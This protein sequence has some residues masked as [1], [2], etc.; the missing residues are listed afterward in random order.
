M[1][2]G[3][4]I[5][6]DSV[7]EFFYGDLFIILFADQF[8][9]GAFNAFDRFDDAQIFISFQNQ[10]KTFLSTF[11]AYAFSNSGRQAAKLASIAS[12]RL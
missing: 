7:T 6:P 1:I 5:D 2:E 10:K 8:I 3:L 12:V 11:S 9:K 4:L